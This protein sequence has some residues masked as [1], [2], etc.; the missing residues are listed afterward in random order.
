M[1][2]DPHHQRGVENGAALLGIQAEPVGQ[3][4]G[5][6]RRAEHVLGGLPQTEVDRNRQ[7]SQDLDPPR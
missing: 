6:R 7:P 2:P 4:A 1:A 3:P 5:D